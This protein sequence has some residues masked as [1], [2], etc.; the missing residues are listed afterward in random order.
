MQYSSGEDFEDAPPANSPKH[1]KT[2][3]SV[4]ADDTALN[5]VEKEDDSGRP[6][7]LHSV[8][9]TLQTE[10]NLIA[11]KPRP[12]RLKCIK[13]F[14]HSDSFMILLFVFSTL[15]FAFTPY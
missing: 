10:P 14:V 1:G 5:E 2:E 9:T 4:T 7:D 6:E 3:T 11:V 15:N 8:D 13:K 12:H